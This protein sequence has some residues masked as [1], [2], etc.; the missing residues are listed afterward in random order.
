VSAAPVAGAMLANPFPGLRPFHENEQHLFFGRESQ[1]DTMIDKLAATQFL[2]VVGTSGSGKSSLVNCGLKPALRRGVMSSAG[3]SWRMAHFRPGSDPIKAMAQS[4]VQPDGLFRMEDF[5]GVPVEP[6]IEATL[7]MSKVGL[8]D[9]YEQAILPQGTNL[10]V[11][12]DQ[13]EELFRYRNLQPSSD[14]VQGTDEKAVAFVNL[15]L[16]ADSSTRPI[17]VVIT[18]RSDFLGDCAQFFGLPEAINRG[19]YL[20]P[21]MS[22]DE[23]RA[24]IAGPVA[25]AGGQISP[26][27]L[28]RLVNDVGDNPDQLSILQHA[29]N[30]TWAEWQRQGGAG[31]MDLPHYEA[32]GT[33]T[34]ALDYHAEKAYSELQGDEQKAICEKIFQAITDKGTDARGI[35]RPTSAATLCAITGASIDE[36]TSVLASFRKPSR[37]FVM[38]PVSDTITPDTVIDISHESL[39]RVWNRLKSWVEDEADSAD[40]YQ[41]LVQNATLHAKGAAGLM[42]DPELSLTLD[43]Q[44]KRKPTAA[45]GE[46]YRPGFDA[47]IKFLDESRQ[48]RDA[49][50][51]AEK[52]RQRRELRRTRIVAAVMGAA[53][54]VSVGLG[55]FAL[56]QQHRA[57]SE[58][59]AAE[60]AKT[61]TLA[62][63]KARQKADEAAEIQRQ[64]TVEAVKAQKQAEDARQQA[65]I[66]RMRAEVAEARTKKANNIFTTAVQ[67]LNEAEGSDANVNEKRIAYEDAKNSHAASDVIAADKQELDDAEKNRDSLKFD[68][69]RKMAP[70]AALLADA[71]IIEPFSP[72]H[73]S[74]SDLFDIS[75]GTVVTDWSGRGSGSRQDDKCGEI[76]E[77][78]VNPND[79]FSG[80]AG[81]SCKATVFA[82]RQKA[83]TEHWIQWK[84]KT[85]VSVR[86]V[87]LFAAHNPKY[88]RRSFRTFRLF[89][90][91]PNGEWKQI[92]DYH[93]SLMFGGN[94]SQKPC[95]PPPA[96]PYFDGRVLAA[97]IRIA[98]TTGQEFRAEFQQTVSGFAG[99]SGPRIL[100]LD[101]YSDSNCENV[102]AS[103]VSS[104]P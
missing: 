68:A 87:G 31:S 76:S 75:R 25:V 5:E 55:A 27:L 104:I 69:A 60:K 95:Y 37:S 38:P 98:P 6:I 30:R 79:M 64:L 94:C 56:L 70:G 65:D 50:I 16:E 42:T 77:T 53:F 48:A 29:L 78:T 58:R 2:A 99:W 17:Y 11:I 39:M 74:G 91:Q 103:G 33:M 83:G 23:R 90:K 19:Q 20:V 54:L 93:P 52:E 10:L 49:A 36:L 59:I 44:H 24:A 71:R 34:H 12:V 85:P 102:G 67:A 7:R 46:R 3:T 88:Y 89:V 63:A 51:E 80:S 101:G 62:Q 86:S 45:W 47:A 9:C 61:E 41:R 92:V 57:E 84:T 22:R 4:L 26:I 82:D 1:I 14:G 72:S 97:C 96:P 32:I 15:L 43:W 28:T 81:S 21:R 18:M 100:Q 35:R 8:V 66:Q 40:Q 13:F 73:I